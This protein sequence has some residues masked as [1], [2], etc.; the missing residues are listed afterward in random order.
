MLNNQGN[1][2]RYDAKKYYQLIGSG[3]TSLSG[4]YTY[5]ATNVR[6][7]ELS[8]SYSFPNKWFKNVVKDLTLSFI[9][10]NLWMIYNKAPYD[11]EL[12]S[13][14]GTFDQGNDYFMQPSLRSLGF[15]VKLKF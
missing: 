5:S 10:S 6:L 9:A 1:D 15:G 11:P 8:L 7:Q 4:Y 13:S 14:T 3:D 2:A 12:T